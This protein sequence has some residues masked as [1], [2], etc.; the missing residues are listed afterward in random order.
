MTWCYT[1]WGYGINICDF[2]CSDQELVTWRQL[3]HGSFCTWR[4]SISTKNTLPVITKTAICQKTTHQ[5]PTQNV[6]S[7]YIFNNKFSYSC[8]KIHKCILITYFCLLLSF[9]YC[10]YSLEFN[11][12]ILVWKWYSWSYERELVVLLWH[13]KIHLTVLIILIR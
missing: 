1:E 7:T 13:Q 9:S 11:D 3:T 10:V 4:S 6:L 12:T 8:F 5:W 2:I